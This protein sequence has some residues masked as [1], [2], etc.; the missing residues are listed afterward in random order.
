MPQPEAE[1]RADCVHF[2]EIVLDQDLVFI[3]GLAEA[4][5][6][7]RGEECVSQN[8]RIFRARNGRQ[9]I[10]FFANSLRKEKKGYV[11][12]PCETCRSPVIIGKHP[13]LTKG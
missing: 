4:K 5:S 11:S 6:K 8:L 2:Q 3:A 13:W 7:G 1:A 12:I 10:L 9:S